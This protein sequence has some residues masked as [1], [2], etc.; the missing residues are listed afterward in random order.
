MQLKW[1]VSGEKSPTSEYL[2]YLWYR[3]FN[4]LLSTIFIHHHLWAFFRFWYDYLNFNLRINWPLTAPYHFS[5]CCWSHCV[6]C[7]LLWSKP[8]EFLFGTL[9]HT[10]K[11]FLLKVFSSYSLS[12][13]LSLSLFLSLS[14]S[15]SL[16]LSLS[17]S[18]L[19]LSLSLTLT[20]T[21]P[22]GD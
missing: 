16:S 10:H 20:L 3:N 18:L 9:N 14:L 21:L 7:L 6:I 5:A 22:D 2:A 11:N 19:S 8:T 12:L 13:S 1:I 4:L 17:L 15:F